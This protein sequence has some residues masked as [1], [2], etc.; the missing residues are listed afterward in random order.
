MRPFHTEDGSL[1]TEDMLIEAAEQRDKGE[2]P[3]SA[4][5]VRPGRPRLANEPTATMSFKLPQ[6]LVS[7]VKRAARVTDQSTSKFIRDAVVEKAQRV[8]SSR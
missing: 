8:L 5:V 6:S 1:V 2:V 3:G 7:Y 4:G